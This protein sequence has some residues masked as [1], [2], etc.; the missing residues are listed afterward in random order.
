VREPCPTAGLVQLTREIRVMERRMFLGMVAGGLLAAPIVAD[1]QQPGAFPSGTSSSWLVVALPFLL[2]AG[3]VFLLCTGILVLVSSRRRGR[4]LAKILV[5]LVAGS[6]CG[7]FWILLVDTA[8]NPAMP[9][10]M[11]EPIVLV[12]G[13][14]TAL[15]AASL[16]SMANHL[17]QMV[18]LSAM[19]IG[20][21]SLALPIPAL[22]SLFVGGAQAGDLRTVALSAGGL[23]LGVFL[24]FVG[25]RVLRRRRRSRPRA[26]FDLGRPY[27]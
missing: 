8:V 14:V 6:V 7:A 9:D 25:D 4:K 19:A 17:S 13:V 12:V 11:N 3:V 10:A 20:F 27:A 22:I 26:R 5:P 15:V 21:H 16:L 23:L 2:V 18:G 24:V 1:A